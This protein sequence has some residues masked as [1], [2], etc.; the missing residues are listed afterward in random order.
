MDRSIGTLRNGLS[1]L[2]VKENTLLWFMS[3][4]GGLPK[5]HPPTNGGLRDHKG[6][7]YEGGIRVPSI[8]EWPYG[9]TTPRRTDYPCGA[10]DI[11]PILKS[12][13]HVL[14]INPGLNQNEQIH[15]TKFKYIPIT[16]FLF[17]RVFA[18]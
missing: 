15:P 14:N 13:N 9:I 10:V 1:K 2:S 12:G 16:H 4:N 18:C 5:I 11:F 17:D 6:S 7:L 3:D 8:I